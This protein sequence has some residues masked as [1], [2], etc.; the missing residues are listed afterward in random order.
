MTTVETLMVPETVAEARTGFRTWLA[1][2]RAPLEQFRETGGELTEIF[3]RLRRLQRMLYDAGWIRLGW[4]ESAGGL[5]GRR[6][7]RSIISEELAHAGYPPPFSFATQ[8]VLGPA[9][10]EFAPA[11]LAAV[12]L[13]RLLQGEETWCQGF[14]EPGAGSEIGRA[15]CRERV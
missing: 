15:S 12:A 2:N 9:V 8:E 6:I 5:G 13:P 4:P 11:E 3:D 10:A 7:L 1:E 14:S